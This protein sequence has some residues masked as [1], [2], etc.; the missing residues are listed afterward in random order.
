MQNKKI[1][2]IK[3]ARSLPVLLALL[4][5]VTLGMIC[6]NRSN[7]LCDE[8][9]RTDKIITVGDITLNAQIADTPS[10]RQTGLSGKKCLS[11]RQAMLFTFDSTDIIG[12]WM[13]EMNFSIDILWLNK[14]K[15]VVSIEK[16]AKPE[17]YPKVFYPSDPALYVIEVR[18][19]IVNQIGIAV[20]QK[21]NW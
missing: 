5:V 4:V 19:G 13:K 11:E 7:S 8:S 6:I 1:E 20:G 21:L 16:N 9:Y 2:K 10:A 15:T 17:S 14:D 18:S 3:L 12:I